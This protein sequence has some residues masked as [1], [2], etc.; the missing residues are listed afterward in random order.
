MAHSLESRVPFLD[1]ELAELAWRLPGCLKVDA[2]AV[3]ADNQEMM[4]SAAGKRVLRRAMKAFLPEEFTQQRKQGF[5]PPD[6][7]WYRGPSLEYIKEILLDPRTRQRPWFDQSFVET[8]LNEHSSGQHNHRLLIWSLLSFEWIQ[9]HFIDQDVT[10][11]PLL[12]RG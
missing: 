10:Q 7:N 4:F 12:S 3:L 8:K 9:R 1:N 2:D 6:E 5:S 11:R